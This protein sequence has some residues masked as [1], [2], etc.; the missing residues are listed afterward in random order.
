MTNRTFLLYIDGTPLP[1]VDNTSRV[2]NNR[3]VWNWN[4]KDTILS[5]DFSLWSWI[6]KNLD[7]LLFLYRKLLLVIKKIQLPVRE[8]DN[9]ELFYPYLSVHFKTL[10]FKLLYFS[11]VHSTSF[12]V[13][14]VSE[15]CDLA[16]WRLHRCHLG[17]SSLQFV[18]PARKF[19]S[20]ATFKLTSSS[21]GRCSKIP[22]VK[23]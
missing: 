10:R 8:G 14:T 21:I 11:I 1:T 18:I 19:S 6:P 13:C 9:H 23:E 20:S 15:Q 5:Q 22:L 7:P 2:W 17:E 4:T 3:K 16:V 12:K